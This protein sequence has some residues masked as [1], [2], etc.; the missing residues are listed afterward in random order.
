MET[1]TFVDKLILA[2]VLL[3]IGYG[4]PVWLCISWLK[5]EK[6]DVN[7]SSFQTQMDSHGGC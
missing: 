1:W 6:K 2:I 3:F 4:I 7:K 5:E